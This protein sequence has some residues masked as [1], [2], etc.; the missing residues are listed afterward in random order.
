MF[1]LIFSAWSRIKTLKC[2]LETID[3]LLESKRAKHPRRCERSNS[4]QASGQV[5][6]GPTPVVVKMPQ[7]SSRP[8][9]RSASIVSIL[10]D[11]SSAGR[12]MAY[13]VCASDEKVSSI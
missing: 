2:H 8:E 7:I 4:R 12:C 6:N 5:M 11:Y 13:H 1:I 10:E 3:S 9:L